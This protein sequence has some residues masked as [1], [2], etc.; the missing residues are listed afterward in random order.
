MRKLYLLMIGSILLLVLM[1]GCAGEKQKD[2][3]Q[4]YLGKKPPGMTPLPFAPEIL[5]A[6]GK[7]EYNLYSS[8][9]FTPDGKQVY[10]TTRELPVSPVYN[11]TIRYMIEINGQW[12]EPMV[13]PFSGQYSDRVEW[14]SDDGQRLYL[15]SDRPLDNSGQALPTRNY[16]VITKTAAGW[17]PPRLVSNPGDFHER[18]GDVYMAG[19]FGDSRGG[20]DIYKI[21]KVDGRHAA[22]LSLGEP[23][24]GPG[25]QFFPLVPKDGS[26]VIFSHNLNDNVKTKGLY[27]SFNLGD[28][29]WSQPV[30]LKDKF[31]FPGLCAA[32]SPDEKYL[33]IVNPD[34]GVYWVDAKVL[35]TFR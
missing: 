31:G 20:I 30:Y 12:S 16:Y 14:L 23:I 11:L 1:A 7:N 27:L 32:L 4:P 19:D 9:F 5:S 22:P 13:A 2:M 25:D 18:D 17:S 28:N 21:A 8:L 10:F 24:N 29:K 35:E 6:S 3:H 33:F 26:W 15:T 34:D